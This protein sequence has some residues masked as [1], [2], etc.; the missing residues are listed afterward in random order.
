MLVQGADARPVVVARAE[1]NF[2]ALGCGMVVVA[3]RLRASA[4]A[5]L[6]LG[7]VVAGVD[8]PPKLPGAGPYRFDIL[9]GLVS[10]RG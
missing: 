1:V 5:S 10:P 3:P 2:R 6:P 9:G 7:G 4:K 8:H